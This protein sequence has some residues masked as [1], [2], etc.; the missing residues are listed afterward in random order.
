MIGFHARAAGLTASILITVACA[1][2]QTAQPPLKPEAASILAKS[3]PEQG[4]TV[5]APVTTLQLHFNSPVRL[6]EVTISGPD[7]LMPMM[8]NAVGEV[9]DYSLPLAGLGPGAYSVNWKATRAGHEFR[10]SFTFTAR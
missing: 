6:D 2:A 8:V 7:G 4:S 5:P 3:E 10:G 1:S 9:R